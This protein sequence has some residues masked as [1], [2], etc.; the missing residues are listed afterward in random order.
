M[1]AGGVI[2]SGAVMVETRAEAQVRLHRS[3]LKE[4]VK[5]N[6]IGR[7]MVDFICDEFHPLL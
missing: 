3:A 1:L 6:G 7:K 5:G 4:E 2:P